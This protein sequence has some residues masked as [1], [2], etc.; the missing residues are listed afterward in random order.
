MIISRATLEDAPAVAEI[1]VRTWQ[2]AYASILTP[3][4]LGSLSVANREE[5][6]RKTI[7]AGNPELLVAKVDGSIRGF[8]CFAPCRDPGALASEAEIWAIYVDP[9]SWKAGIGRE[10]WLHTKRGMLEHGYKTCS[11][12]VFPQNHRAIRFYLAA[13]FVPDES[14]SKAFDM[15]GQR[16]TEARYV[17]DLKA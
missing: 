10:L 1:H 12:W 4:Y 3:E 5:L 6:W 16:L 2:V 15:D 8:I 11:L 7:T 9:D 17:A 14:R 13:G